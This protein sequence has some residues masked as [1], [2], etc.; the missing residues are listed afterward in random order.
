MPNISPQSDPV[1]DQLITAYPVFRDAQPLAIGIHKAIAAAH[2]E[3][4]NDE[5]CKALRRH[6][7][8]TRYLKAI[9]SESVRF[10]L[11]GTP[12]GDISRE[13]QEL[14]CGTV[15]ERFRKQAERRRAALK[16]QEHQAKLN[17]LVDKFRQPR[18]RT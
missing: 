4:N 2:P 11:D 16:D 9:A 17:Q 7:S 15:K 1:L 5:L 6:T 13:Q 8:S 18:Q 10:G 14:A 12:V 3:I